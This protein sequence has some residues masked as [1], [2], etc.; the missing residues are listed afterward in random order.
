MTRIYP[1]IHPS[2]RIHPCFLSSFRVSGFLRQPD[3]D[4]PNGTWAWNQ[5]LV[6]ILNRI[7]YKH[8]HTHTHINIE[9]FIYKH[10]L[11]LVYFFLF[12]LNIPGQCRQYWTKLNIRGLHCFSHW[13]HSGKTGQI[14]SIIFLF[15]NFHLILLHWK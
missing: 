10:G 12:I 5:N 7:Q 13:K 4:S 6:I 1:S 11:N 8:T 14:I 3:N 15:I 9:T 2:Y